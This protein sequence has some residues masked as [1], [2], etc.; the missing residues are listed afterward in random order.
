MSEV[1]IAVLNMSISASY[2][3]LAVLLLRL[4]FRKAP[5]WIKTALWGI[6]SIRLICPVSLKSVLS[7]IPNP[8][9]VPPEIMMDRNPEINTGLPIVNK[10]INP[11]IKGAFT[12]DP[13]T[14]ANPLQLWIPT[15]SLF[16]IIGILALL[17][18]TLVSYTR[19]K[20][21]TATA[22]LLRDNI[23]QSE[24]VV[25]PFVI[26]ICKPRI[27]LPF[28]MNEKDVAHVLAHETAHIRRK[29]HILKPVGFLLLIL[30]WFNPLVWIGYV[31]L[32]RDIE[33]ACDEKVI[34]TL[35]REARADYSQALLNCG[36]DRRAIAACPL[37]F[38]E[39]GVKKR[40]RSVL[41]YKKPALWIIIAAIAVCAAVAVCFLTDP[42][43]VRAEGLFSFEGTPS[44]TYY[45]TEDGE[46]SMRAISFDEK[47]AQEILSIV[48]ECQWEELGFSFHGDITFHFNEPIAYM[49]ETGM[50]LDHA[51]NRCTYLD[52]ITHA[53]L[54]RLI[55]QNVGCT[56][57]LYDAPNYSAMMAPSAVPSLEISD[58][59]LY[60]VN[61]GNRAR[62][63]TVKKTSLTY[64]NFEAFFLR[65]EGLEMYD[66]S[67]SAKTLRLN[68]KTAYE[69]I[70][71][72]AQG[73][74]F[75]YI[76]EQKTG[77]TVI[78]YGHY[79]ENGEKKNEIRFVYQRVD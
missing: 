29:D 10:V 53:K 9:T 13:A 52:S 19:V 23:Y 69:V 12:P 25:S 18:Y 31:M 57:L 37:A 2:L 40:V 75:Y 15:F 50:L 48:N 20:R 34:K 8:Q 79:G 17:I 6:A 70:P 62:I 45:T 49:S 44:C 26:G 4:L 59:V 35:D 33:L 66:Y 61:E 51:N 56:T 3:I 71:D 14:S 42:L 73:L 41:R 39:V 28:R 55:F 78:V 60:A 22:V 74:N 30:H 63:G 5:G 32:C 77:E 7:L 54:N 47:T 36:A 24:N 1:F 46:T 16:W 38:G 67:E 43:N 27:Y 76:M 65:Y 68:N 11:V 72:D 21:R 58:G 64:F